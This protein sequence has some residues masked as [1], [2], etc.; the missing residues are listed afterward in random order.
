MVFG[1]YPRHRLEDSGY[2]ATV[3]PFISSSLA[4]ALEAMIMNLQVT[5]MQPIG[6]AAQTSL[7]HVPSS[8]ITTSRAHQSDSRQRRI[9]SLSTLGIPD[10]GR[11]FVVTVTHLLG[12]RELM[13]NCRFVRQDQNRLDNC[14]ISR[15][16]QHERLES[17]LE[18][19]AGLT[20][21]W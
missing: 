16:R 12:A 19:M 8:H 17:R 14:S 4:I 15:Q 13:V 2:G 1:Y 7:E 21:S 10:T 9:K 18:T 20:E 3:Q 5:Y 11:R 6:K